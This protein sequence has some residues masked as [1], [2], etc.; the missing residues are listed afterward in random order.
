MLP[1]LTGVLTAAEQAFAEATVSPLLVDAAAGEFTAGQV[2]VL[3][4]PLG[5]TFEDV[6]PFKFSNTGLLNT[7]GMVLPQL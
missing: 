5:A 1:A 7:I 2:G 6:A 3:L 4:T